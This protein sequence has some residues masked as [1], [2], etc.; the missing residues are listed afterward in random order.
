MLE[1]YFND[2]EIE[3][4][5]TL[6]S[7]LKFLTNLTYHELDSTIL[8]LFIKNNLCGKLL[9]FEDYTRQLHSLTIVANLAAEPIISSH[10]LNNGLFKDIINLCYSLD[11][12]I[13][14][15]QKEMVVNKLANICENVTYKISPKYVDQSMKLCLFLSQAFVESDINSEIKLAATKSIY[16]LSMVSEEFVTE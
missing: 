4:S 9:K 1:K 16:H 10:M 3:D 13:D 7:I 8:Q 2:L 6:V 14:Q 5:W 15:S 11:E 12:Y